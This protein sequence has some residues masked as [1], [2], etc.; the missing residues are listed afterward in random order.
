MAR[1]DP[2]G[3]ESADS[4]ASMFPYY[5]ELGHIALSLEAGVSSIIDEAKSGQYAIAPNQHRGPI[6]LGPVLLQRIGIE[7]PMRIQIAARR[8]AP[9]FREIVR[10]ELYEILNDC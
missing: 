3:G 9:E 6:G 7:Q 2:L 10:V 4:A 1:K 8:A 5:E